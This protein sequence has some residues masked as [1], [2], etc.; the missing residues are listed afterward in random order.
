MTFSQLQPKL[1]KYLLSCVG[2]RQ[3]TECL[4]WLRSW[5]N[6]WLGSANMDFCLPRFVVLFILRE[7]HPNGAGPSTAPSLPQILA[8]LPAALSSLFLFAMSQQLPCP[9]HELWTQC[10]SWDTWLFP[11]SSRHPPCCNGHLWFVL[12]C[13]LLEI[14]VGYIQLLLMVDSPSP[15]KCRGLLGNTLCKSIFS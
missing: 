4:F 14:P 13:I 10:E 11:C 5:G 15:S 12:L 3:V 1:E 2:H 9:N 7:Q 6:T 8:A